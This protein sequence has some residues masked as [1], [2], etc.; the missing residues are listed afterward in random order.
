MASPCCAASSRARSSSDSPGWSRAAAISVASCSSELE[1]SSQ[2]ARIDRQLGERRP[3]RPPA[4]DRGG[5]LATKLL[6][7]AERVEQVALP[8][9][10]EQP[11]LLVLAVDL[12]ERP[13][14]L[15]QPRRGHGLV[16]EP[17]RRAAAGGDLANRNDRLGNPVEE[18][19]DPGELRAVPDQRCV[20]ARSQG[21]AERVDEQALAGAG[22]PGDHVQPGA[23][24]E[25]EPI[26]QREIRDRQLE[27]AAGRGGV[28]RVGH[29]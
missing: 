13:D 20:G 27:Q 4:L 16:V 17:G 15:G 9:L 22:L 18:R 3:V 7:A 26:D 5:H 8:T 6:V 25:A 11:L 12:D 21:E 28:G 29:P 1:P 2:L 14:L 23:E 24:L 19:L 10:I